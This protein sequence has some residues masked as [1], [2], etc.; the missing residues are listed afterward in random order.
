MG[1]ALLGGTASRALVGQSAS[2]KTTF[3][4]ICAGCHGAEAAGDV[5]PRLVPFTKS[6]RE[7][8]GIV[9]EGTGQMPALSVRD[10]TDEEVVGVAEYLRSLSRE[11]PSRRQPGD[12]QSHPSRF[13]I[14]SST[15][16][17][18][19]PRALSTEATAMSE[20][21]IRETATRHRDAEAAE[22]QQAPERRRQ[23]EADRA[24]FRQH[25][26]QLWSELATALRKRMH[27]YNE[28]IGRQ[29]LSLEHHA[30]HLFLRGERAGQLATIAITVLPTS[31]SSRISI[32]TRSGGSTE[33]D[34][35]WVVTHPLDNHLAFGEEGTAPDVGLNGTADAVLRAVLEH[36]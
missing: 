23:A 31:F 33:S 13:C 32:G 7:L 16:R 34:G 18:P 5:G 20:D 4:R 29:V 26:P 8:L 25:F 1:A 17:A 10:I 11:T 21:W 36:L 30:D 2:G 22:Q 6:N 35:P 15:E 14:D 24:F 27:V 3:D 19:K 12:N 9:R 28:T